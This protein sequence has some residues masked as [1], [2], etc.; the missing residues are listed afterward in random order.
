MY[1]VTVIN[2]KFIRG[3]MVVYPYCLFLRVLHIVLT[4][5][6]GSQADD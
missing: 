2:T 3:R 4:P 1:G 6:L 5:H